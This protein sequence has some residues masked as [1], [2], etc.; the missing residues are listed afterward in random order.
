M[1]VY[2]VYIPLYF[3]VHRDG[4]DIFV[5]PIHPR[6]IV[7]IPVYKNNKNPLLPLRSFLTIKKIYF[8]YSNCGIA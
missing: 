1:S 4:K 5:H 6:N 3:I 7:F 8:Y 2:D